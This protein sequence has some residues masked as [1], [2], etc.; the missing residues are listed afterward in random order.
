M[1]TRSSTQL[2][3]H[4]KFS[5][6]HLMVKQW[7]SLWILSIGTMSEDRSRLR[8]ATKFWINVLQL[9]HVSAPSTPSGRPQKTNVFIIW[10]CCRSSMCDSS[11]LIEISCWQNCSSSSEI[12][13]LLLS[14]EESLASMADRWPLIWTSRDV[15][16]SSITSETSCMK[17]PIAFLNHTDSSPGKVDLGPSPC[18]GLLWPAAHQVEQEPFLFFLE[19]YWTVLY[20]KTQCN[21]S[22]SLNATIECDRT[23]CYT[24]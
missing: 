24:H 20:F 19:A 6:T 8:L 14:R 22:F 18:R 21:F 16:F 1:L 2:K 23:R 17:L 13:S 7:W 3:Q 5:H 12:R 9:S 15:Y 11:F 10:R 4:K